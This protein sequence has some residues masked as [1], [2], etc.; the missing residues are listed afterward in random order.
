MIKPQEPSIAEKISDWLNAHKIMC[1]SLGFILAGSMTFFTATM[2]RGTEQSSAQ[3]QMNTNMVADDI[4]YQNDKSAKKEKEKQEST[5]TKKDKAITD[6]KNKSNEATKQKAKNATKST[7]KKQAKTTSAPKAQS[8]SQSDAQP[9]AQPG[10]ESQG[11]DFIIFKLASTPTLFGRGL[12]NPNADSSQAALDTNGS[13]IVF[14]YDNIDESYRAST[15]VDWYSDI[16]CEIYIGNTKDSQ[17][18]KYEL[19]K[20][21]YSDS[22]VIMPYMSQTDQICQ[23]IYNNL[24]QQALINNGNHIIKSFGDP[25]DVSGS[26]YSSIVDHSDAVY[27]EYDFGDWKN[28]YIGTVDNTYPNF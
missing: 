27:F 4:E 1:A 28:E 12:E 18:S 26:Y 5:N 15:P 22:S 2:M 13:D 7:P 21:G 10:P 19:T 3:G 25:Y 20:P 8:A 23:Y 16:N 9:E 6:K 14:K 11:Q 24:G 17:V